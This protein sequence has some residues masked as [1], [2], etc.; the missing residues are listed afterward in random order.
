MASESA[1]WM[2]PGSTVAGAP[3]CSAANWQAWLDEL[4]LRHER[5][6]R[7]YMQVMKE[8]RE[9]L[10]RAEWHGMQAGELRRPLREGPK[11]APLHLLNRER[12]SPG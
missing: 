10:Q 6:V 2:S 12:R 1:P 9:A 4:R 5:Q 3:S 7:Q 8:T 11:T